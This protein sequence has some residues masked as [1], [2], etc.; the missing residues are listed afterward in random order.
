ME[1]QSTLVRGLTLITLF[2]LITGAMVG[3]AWAILANVLLDRAGPAVVLSLA[4]AAFLS[5][6]IGLCFAEL[7]SA[8]PYAGGE[9]IYVKRA[10]GK[11]PGFITGWI[12][13]LAYAA[14]MPGE[15]I[16]IGKLVN[17]IL[18][19]FSPTV[20]GVTAAILFTVIN[21]IGIRLSGLVQFLLTSALFVGIL[22][23]VFAGLPA[24]ELSNFEPFFGRGVGGIFIMIPIAM[25]AYMGYDVLPQAAEEVD[26]PIRKMVFIIPAS[27]F[28]VGFVYVLVIVVTAGLV[29]WEQIA[30]STEHIPIIPA[31]LKALGEKGPTI[32]II[33]GVCGLI[34]TMNAFLVGGSRLL[35]AMA[36]DNELPSAFKRIHQRF[37]V[38]SVGIIFLGLLGVAGSFIKELI[39]LFDTAASS[40]LI[41]YLL[42]AIA[43]IVLRRKEPGLDRPYRVPGYPAV[44][45][46]AIVAVIPT[47]L[48]SLAILKTWALAVYFGWIVLGCGYYLIIRRER[49]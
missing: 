37:H 24:L 25:L 28:F 45:I 40:V 20:I 32:I 49:A 47:W 17:G 34:T 8:M 27:I 5:L 12:L 9:Y 23:Y 10:L 4:I 43:L 18:P 22:I 29:P 11:F 6:F 30:K 26:A 33:A 21:L 7:C 31:V 19:Q 46:V 42:V 13:V 38:P 44:P 36:K 16:I 14:M 2:T 41:C 15:C 39:V 1:K 48:I 3:M 35:M